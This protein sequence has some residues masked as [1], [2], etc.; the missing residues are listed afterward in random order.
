MTGQKHP[1]TVPPPD[2][3]ADLEALLEVRLHEEGV[4][5][6]GQDLQQLV[7]GDE[8][9]AREGGPLRLEEL[10]QLLQD[11]VQQAVG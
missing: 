3:S 11:L 2:P 4:L 5:R 7:V 10:L 9:E 1:Q 6:L 8:V